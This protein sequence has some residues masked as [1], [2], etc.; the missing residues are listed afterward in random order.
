MWLCEYE[1]WK[2]LSEQLYDLGTIMSTLKS[3]K[4]R[5]IIYVLWSK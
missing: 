2:K 4:M 1:K 3:F 5:Q